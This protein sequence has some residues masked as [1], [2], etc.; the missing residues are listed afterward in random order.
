MNFRLSHEVEG[1]VSKGI[2]ITGCTRSGTTMMGQLV[3]SLSTVEYAEEPPMIRILLSLIH[4]LPKKIF[5]FF[6]EGYIFEEHM[7]FTIPGR[8]INLNKFD[9]SSIYNS[10][11]INEIEKRL[12]KSYRRLEIFPKALKSTPALKLPEVSSNLKLLFKY[13]PEMRIII[14]LRNP[15]S[16]L[17]SMIQKEWYTDKAL[18]GRHGQWL[19]LDEKISKKGN[20][21]DWLK[22]KEVSKFY[23]MSE[24]ERGIM[25]YIYEYQNIINLGKNILSKK[26]VIV[27]DYNKFVSQPDVYF[28]K[29]LNKFS[30]EFG[31]KTNLILKRVKE[32]K[33]D[34]N[35]NWA[36]I[37]KKIKYNLFDLYEK[38]LKFSI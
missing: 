23:S 3:S 1:I 38:C 9:Q 18:Y 35:I 31:Q 37:D 22:K 14:M 24:I 6:F 4:K 21:P 16:V 34:R 5:K 29:I 32:P 11:S 27:L 13:Y 7:M 28:N 20:T 33:K 17:S 10:K 36:L 12:N 30:L 19:F 25:Y 8:K 15:E 2:F 26:N